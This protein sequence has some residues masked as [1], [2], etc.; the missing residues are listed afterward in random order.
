MTEETYTY[1]AGE[2]AIINVA[3]SVSP[4]RRPRVLRRCTP[5]SSSSSASS[6]TAKTAEM[7]KSIP[8]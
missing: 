7:I 6:T 1:E 5:T 8:G 4:R 2:K 3:R